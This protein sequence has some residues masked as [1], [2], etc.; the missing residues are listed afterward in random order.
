MTL[1]PSLYRQA[2]RRITDLKRRKPPLAQKSA[3]IARANGGTPPVLGRG[4]FDFVSEITSSREA[5]SPAFVSTTSAPSS[6]RLEV[7]LVSSAFAP[8]FKAR[9]PSPPTPVELTIGKVWL[10]PLL[11]SSFSG[12]TGMGTI[13]FSG[14]FFTASGNVSPNVSL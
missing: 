8:S 2:F 5:V 9:H 7:P 10:G 1:C 13:I 6:S 4:F 11:N 3:A 12:S 14:L